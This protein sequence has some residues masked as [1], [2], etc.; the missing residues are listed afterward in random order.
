MALRYV[1]GNTTLIPFTNGSFSRA[2]GE[3]VAGGPNG[4]ESYG[5]MFESADASEPTQLYVPN[6]SCVFEVDKETPTDT[7]A[8]FALVECTAGRLLEGNTDTGSA[9]PSGDVNGAVVLGRAV[10][11]SANGDAT[12]KVLLIPALD[13][14]TAP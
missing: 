14:P 13:N 8:M 1:S 2:K 5:V 6:G 3:I 12:V 10:E 11:A 4:N 7:F 9:V